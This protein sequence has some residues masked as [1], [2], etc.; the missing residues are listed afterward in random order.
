MVQVQIK[1]EKGKHLEISGWLLSGPG[2]L[3]MLSYSLCYVQNFAIFAN[4]FVQNIQSSLLFNL[5]IG[6]IGSELEFDYG[7]V[8][9]RCLLNKHLIS[10]FTWRF[11]PFILGSPSIF[12]S[13]RP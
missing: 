2:R 6:D 12:L 5:A 13:N 9:A 7:L 3:L 11:I 1:F 8:I 10:I 4:Y